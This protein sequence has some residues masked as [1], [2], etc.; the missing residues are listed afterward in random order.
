M[1][2]LRTI[3]GVLMLLG[4]CTVFMRSW[5]STA[6]VLAIVSTMVAA[7]TAGQKLLFG[8]GNRGCASILVGACFFPLQMSAVLVWNYFFAPELR[9]DL[10]AFTVVPLGSIFA[11]A[12]F[13]YLVG[14]VV[15][16]VSVV[17]Q[18][19]AQQQRSEGGA[20]EAAD[21]PKPTDVVQG[22]RDHKSGSSA[23]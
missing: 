7:V 17:P 6:V 12:L 21:P 3:V 4:L 20:T 23:L 22:E 5:Q 14:W 8:G 11:G 16:L 9:V 10:F 19:L 2:S 15:C 1:R 13:G 18:V